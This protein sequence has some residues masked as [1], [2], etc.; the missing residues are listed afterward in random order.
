MNNQSAGSIDCALI[1]T[2]HNMY[3]IIMNKY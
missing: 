2:Y 3:K 1:C